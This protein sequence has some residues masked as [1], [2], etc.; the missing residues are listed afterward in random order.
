MKR[1]L[2]PRDQLLYRVS[3]SH[4]GIPTTPS[5][6]EAAPLVSSPRICNLG[7]LSHTAPVRIEVVLGC[8]QVLFS[9]EGSRHDAA[10]VLSSG[11]LHLEVHTPD[12]GE[13]NHYPHPKLSI[14]SSDCCML[15]AKL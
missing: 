5:S 6:G 4:G 8:G 1:V 9:R 14:N 10:A 3:E 13:I 7:G 12:R 2:C 11:L 15:K